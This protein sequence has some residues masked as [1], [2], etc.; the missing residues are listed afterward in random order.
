MDTILDALSRSTHYV[1]TNYTEE[2]TFIA[3]RAVHLAA[4]NCRFCGNY[5]SSTRIIINPKIY[6][7]CEREPEYYDDEEDEE[8]E[9]PSDEE[10]DDED[11]DE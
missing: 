3:E 6:C 5:I 10:E 2:W 8:D 11:E 7:F 4:T 9:Y 1:H